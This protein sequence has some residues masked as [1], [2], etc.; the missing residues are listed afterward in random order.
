MLPQLRHTLMSYAHRKLFWLLACFYIF[1]TGL[2]ATIPRRAQPLLWRETQVRSLPQQHFDGV[3]AFLDWPATDEELRELRSL[4]I[5]GHRIVKSDKLD[6][7]GKPMAMLEQDA[8]ITSEHLAKLAK[9]VQLTELHWFS[10]SMTPKFGEAL[11]RL[12]NLR[13]LELS[14]IGSPTPSLQ[15]LPPLS[16]LRF[17]QVPSVPPAELGLLARHPLLTTVELQDSVP[18]GESV[19]GLSEQAQAVWRQPSTLHEAIQIER[20]IIRQASEHTKAV[21]EGIPYDRIPMDATQKSIPVSELLTTS[22][23]KLPNLKAVEIRDAW[24]GGPVK[25]SDDPGVLGALSQRP[26]VSINPVVR[27]FESTMS[28]FHA[29][30]ATIVIAILGIQLYSQF[31]AS[32]SRTVPSFASPHLIVAGGLLLTHLVIMAAI[33]HGFRSVAVIPAFALAGAFPALGALLIGIASRRPALIPLLFPLLFASAM[34]L[35]GVAPFYFQNTGFADL[36]DGRRPF[37]KVLVILVEIAVFSWAGHSLMTLPRRLA[38]AG[39]PMGLGFTQ[40][41]QHLQMKKLQQPKSTNRPMEFKLRLLNARIESFLVSKDYSDR[42]RQWRAGEPGGWQN[43]L[44]MC[45][46]VPWIVVGTFALMMRL[47][48][49]H[50]ITPELFVFFS[51]L[52]G[53]LSLALATL[54]LAG[55]GLSRRPILQQELLRPML[56][57]EMGQHVGTSIWVDLWPPLFLT[58]VYL[59]VLTAIHSWG[60][61]AWSSPSWSV[62]TLGHAL[63]CMTL[64]LPIWAGL[65]W[66]LTIQKEMWRV[67]LGFVGYF[68]LFGLCQ[69]IVLAKLLPFSS[70]ST[71]A[72]IASYL[73]AGVCILLGTVLAW[74]A[75]R[76]LPNVEWGRTG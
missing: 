5:V 65:L 49:Q 38:E 3:T 27:S 4:R 74:L 12:P 62:N 76:R 17:F 21:F 66:L 71:F 37:M 68:V 50:S 56:R 2:E 53:T 61:L 18:I 28:T 55:G 6:P 59:F 44:P 46:M 9:C 25:M 39:I 11:A 1:F 60:P 20:L 24:A 33:L 69:A 31:S 67:F 73:G 22:L 14:L 10:V 63:F 7:N 30:S 43:L 8:E 34:G 29:F 15:S 41:L 19:F 42:R 13:H 47:M 36:L 23:A 54:V 72:A 35:V 52:L 58:L 70:T 51:V 16:Q 45:I 64:P 48:G 26:D 75:H 57:K 32:W 40:T